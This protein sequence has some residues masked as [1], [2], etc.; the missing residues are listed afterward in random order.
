MWPWKELP[1]PVNGKQGAYLPGNGRTIR[2]YEHVNARLILDDMISK[3]ELFAEGE[4]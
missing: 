1:A 2:V 4:E 3:L